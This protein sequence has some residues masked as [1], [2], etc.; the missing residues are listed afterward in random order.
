MPRIHTCLFFIPILLPCAVLLGQSRFSSGEFKGFTVSPT[1]HIINRYEEEVKAHVF[2][3]VVVDPSGF[4]ISGVV[5][6]VR[7]PGKNEHVKG[8]LTDESG[9]FQ[10]RHL[11]VGTYAFKVTSNGFQSVVGQVQ[12]VAASGQKPLVRITLKVGV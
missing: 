9:R 11:R 4:P 6:E 3:G 8:T 1:E 5:V 7:G 2:L 12:I 10:F